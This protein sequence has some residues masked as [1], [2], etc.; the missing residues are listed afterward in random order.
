MAEALQLGV[1]V[2]ARRRRLGRSIG[3]TDNPFLVLAHYS[4]CG[5]AVER[6]LSGGGV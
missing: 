6:V 2:I 1:D 5:L 3:N 4:P